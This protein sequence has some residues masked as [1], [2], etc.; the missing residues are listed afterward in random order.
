MV[1][2]SLPPTLA[3]STRSSRL[4]S[5]G[6]YFGIAEAA[7]LDGVD[8]D[9]GALPGRPDPRALARRSDVTGMPVQAVWA[10]RVVDGPLHG[11]RLRRTLELVVG[12][13]EATGAPTVV[14]DRA[15]PGGGRDRGA[16][17]RA[18]RDSLPPATRLTVTLRPRHL[19]G[20][21]AHLTQL[22]ALRRLAE[23]WDHDLALD[24]LGPIDPGWEAEA[25]L[26]R[27]LP[28]LTLIRFGPLESRPP[29]RGRSRVT[30][31]VLAAAVDAGFGG[32]ASLVVRPP[33]LQGFWRPALTAAC[34][35]TGRLLRDRFMGPHAS[36]PFD[37]FPESRPRF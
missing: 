20:T 30:A 22:T 36:L 18:L 13:V 28:R 17:I 1:N 2:T 11:W 23:E 29:G 35:E 12:L 9:L 32:V 5:P 6:A 33:A 31:R 26:A 25:A 27:L 8:L 15:E 19:A 16:P 14:V 10:P 3:V 7:G 4:V 34:A 21:R 24:L 37:A